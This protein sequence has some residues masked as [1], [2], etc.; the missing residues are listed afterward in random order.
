MI[1]SRS[2][3]GIAIALVIR[4]KDWTEEI[5]SFE[6]PYSLNIDS[7]SL[8]PISSWLICDFMNP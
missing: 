1:A 8:A 6:Y 3:L 2:L 7:A 5:S 4:I